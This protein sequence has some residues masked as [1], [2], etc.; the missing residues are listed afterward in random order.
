MIKQYAP[1]IIVL[2]VAIVAVVGILA[3]STGLFSGPFS[4]TNRLGEATNAL[5]QGYAGSGCTDT[6]G[7]NLPFIAGDVSAKGAQFQDQCLAASTNQDLLIEYFCKNAT[8]AGYS[9]ID[10]KGYNMICSDGACVSA[11]A[12][13]T[14]TTSGSDLAAAS[15]DSFGL[16]QTS[17]FISFSAPDCGSNPYNIASNNTTATT[18]QQAQPQ[19]QGGYFI[20]TPW[21]LPDAV[22]GQQYSFTIQTSPPLPSSTQWPTNVSGVPPGLS[23]S[24]GGIISGTPTTAGQYYLTLGSASF[25][26]T[27]DPAGQT[28]L[29]PLTITSAGMRS[30]PAA[31]IGQPYSTS[32]QATGGTGNYQWAVIRG[33]LPYG[34]SMSRS[35]VI[36]GT[37]TG[38]MLGQMQGAFTVAV[39]DGDSVATQDFVMG[40]NA[41]QCTLS[42]VQNSAFDWW[43]VPPGIPDAAVGTPYQSPRFIGGPFEMTGGSLPPGMAIQVIYPVGNGAIR[44]YYNLTSPGDITVPEPGYGPEFSLVGTPTAPGTYT[45]TLGSPSIDWWAYDPETIRQGASQGSHAEYITKYDQTAT[46]T[47]KV[48]PAGAMTSVKLKPDKVSANPQNGPGILHIM[49]YKNLYPTL[50]LPLQGGVIEALGGNVQNYHWSIISGSLPPG[51]MFQQVPS[52]AFSAYN[53]VTRNSQDQFGNNLALF[54]AAAFTGIPG[55]AGLYPLTIQVTDGNQTATAT[56]SI[57]VAPPS[58]ADPVKGEATIVTICTPGQTKCQGNYQMQTCNPNGAGWT[59]SQCR[60]GQYCINDECQRH[61]DE[62]TAGASQC[63]SNTAMEVCGHNGAWY[64]KWSDPISCDGGQCVAG[65][66]VQSGTGCGGTTMTPNGLGG[67]NTL[68]NLQYIQTSVAGSGY[69]FSSTCMGTN[70]VLDYY[71]LNNAYVSSPTVCRLGSCTKGFCDTGQGGITDLSVTNKNLIVTVT[72]PPS[73]LLPYGENFGDINSVGVRKISP[74][75]TFL[76]PQGTYQLIFSNDGGYEP[77]TLTVTVTAGQITS[78]PP[79]TLQRTCFDTSCDL[80]NNDACSVYGPIQNGIV[81]ANGETYTNTCSGNTLTEWYCKGPNPASITYVCDGNKTIPGCR[82]GLCTPG[83]YEGRCVDLSRLN[84]TI[85]VDS[86]PPGAQV[87]VGWIGDYRGTTPLS[88][89]VPATV[90][91]NILL[92][93]D[94]YKDYITVPSLTLSFN[95]TRT[96]DVTLVHS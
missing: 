11:P 81:T 17:S 32:L 30:L 31:T 43:F 53:I 24:T 36:S 26:L 54:G 8:K 7:G 75:D 96:I 9:I 42:I 66:C 39:S 27:V 29:P 77:Q 38:Y 23:V 52:S 16:P 55:K 5:T 67:F 65:K 49:Y 14:P 40:L 45:F 84:A 10:C 33:G 21:H 78:L 4:L 50:G 85:I 74:A 73:K 3:S 2:S 90:A 62:C 80:I 34:L 68:N 60:S 91:E 63:V 56:M 25:F 28:P 44:L 93:K 41:G 72:T 95:E 70:V 64:N 1:L 37:P 88:V 20:T 6:D 57:L 19:A 87:F 61:P 13:N 22:V 46:I 51:I 69:Q 71:C 35:G 76:L 86:N 83:C 92:K 15:W 82:E 58:T 48:Y 94:G 79:V 59:P 12:A 47:L 89:M 18:A